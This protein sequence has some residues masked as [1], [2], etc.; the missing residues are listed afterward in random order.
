VAEDLK[1]ILA[2]Y[3]AI[4]GTAGFILSLYLALRDRGRIRVILHSDRVAAED[5]G[6]R[7]SWY[8]LVSVINRGRR[9]M[10]VI[11]A[12]LVYYD[13]SEQ[14]PLVIN[15][16]K[17]P[18]FWTKSDGTR[19]PYAQFRQENTL[20][21]GASMLLFFEFGDDVE[22]LPYRA[23]VRDATLTIHRRLHSFDR[24]FEVWWMF[25]KSWVT[26]ARQP[27]RPLRQRSRLSRLLLLYPAAAH[28]SALHVVFFIVLATTI[29]LI[30]FCGMPTY[31]VLLVGTVG[32]GV[33]IFIRWV[34]RK[35]DFAEMPH[36]VGS[37]QEAG[38][39]EAPT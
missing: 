33:S 28:T 16:F 19:A 3:G 27:A 14:A 30:G 21:E 11:D 36:R 39:L 22:V 12:S 7:D 5:W 25:V 24:V 29:I 35:A 37:S 32:L 38:D 26:I 34:A 31:A 23:V 18:A 13:C 20:G 15:R 8:A 1:T 9:A 10:T 17:S 6:N 2:A 4:V